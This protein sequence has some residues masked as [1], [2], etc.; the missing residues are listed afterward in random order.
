VTRTQRLHISPVLLKIRCRRNVAASSLAAT[1]L[2]LSSICGQLLA[3][4]VAA[5]P[6][7][8]ASLQIEAASARY[9]FTDTT[10][11]FLKGF[12]AEGG[13]VLESAVRVP[14]GESK[15]TFWPDLMAG[16]LQMRHQSGDSGLTLWFNP[17]FDAGL[18]VQWKR[19]AEQWQP[20]AA[21]WVLGEDI[22]KTAPAKGEPNSIA[23]ANPATLALK[24][25]EAVFRLV[26]A[27]GWR[28]PQRSESAERIVRERVRAARTA[29]A[30]LQ[31]TE[32]GRTV[33]SAARRLMTLGEPVNLAGKPK[34]KAVLVALGPDVCQRMRVV[35]ASQAGPQ[36][37]TL[38]LESP[39]APSL[40][41]FVTTSKTSDAPVK[42]VDV[43]LARFQQ[44]EV[45]P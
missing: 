5:T 2:A 7:V 38:A 35:S 10:A 25:G 1:L 39:D 14:E 4:S 36:S 18:L 30:N 43:Q 19:G 17:V 15:D 21:W 9:R 12:D 3:E 34:M 33:F 42:I 22:R 29:L 20:E 32:S 31:S 8:R 26:S 6:L 37:W 44:R 45:Q 28:P 41:I 16:A 40:A 11:L 27:P 24:N 23:A 13:R